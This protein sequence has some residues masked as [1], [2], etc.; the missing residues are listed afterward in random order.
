MAP[1]SAMKTTDDSESITLNAKEVKMLVAIFQ[2]AGPDIKVRLIFHFLYSSFGLAI[3][4]ALLLHLAIHRALLLHL[5]NPS[6]SFLF[7]F[8]LLPLSLP[9]PKQVPQLQTN[10]KPTTTFPKR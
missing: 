8:P 1:K 4:R 3:R 10:Q 9:P 7:F 6:P 2:S 5:A